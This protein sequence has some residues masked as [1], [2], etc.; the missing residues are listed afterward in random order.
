MKE[1]VGTCT[2]NVGCRRVKKPAKIVTP[3]SMEL[4]KAP[5]IKTSIKISTHSQKPIIALIR[6]T[7]TVDKANIQYIT[8]K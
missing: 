1:Y 5:S 6:L 8:K 7:F 2:L 3:A 4:T